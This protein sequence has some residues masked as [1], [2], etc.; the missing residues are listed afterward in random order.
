MSNGKEIFPS[1]A[2]RML[3]YSFMCEHELT[4]N[5]MAENVYAAIDA[6]RSYLEY[7][8]EMQELWSTAKPESLPEGYYLHVR[9]AHEVFV[10]DID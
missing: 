5:V 6:V 8:P 4:Y 2:P 7:A 3:V 10:S 1:K 9:D